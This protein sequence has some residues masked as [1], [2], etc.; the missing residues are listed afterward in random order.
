M[1]DEETGR[2]SKSAR[3]REANWLQD[4]GVEL[5]ELKEE[6]IDALDLPERLATALKELK[7]LPTHGA[8][9]RQR[10]YIGKLM[11]GIDTEPV[12]ALLESR[13]RQHDAELR[14]FQRTERWR[15]RLLAEPSARRELLDEYPDADARELDELLAKATRERDHGRPPAAARELFAFLRRLIA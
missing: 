14:R 9:L 4:L 5:A 12:L 2:P 15:D 13:K 11:R 3:K 10:Q 8:Q 7:R 1:S 6:D